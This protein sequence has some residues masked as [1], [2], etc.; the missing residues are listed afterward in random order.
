[1]HDSTNQLQRQS[2]GWSHTLE[3]TDLLTKSDLENLEVIILDL[4]GSAVYWIFLRMKL[5]LPPSITSHHRDC[6]VFF[7][8]MSHRNVVLELSL[9]HI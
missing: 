9:I 1:M 5:F 2:V 4:L 8:S 6:T 3:L 7:T